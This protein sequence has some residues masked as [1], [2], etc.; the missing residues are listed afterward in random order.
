[1]QMMRTFSLSLSVNIKV[2]HVLLCWLVPKKIEISFQEARIGEFET[3][4]QV[5]ERAI[6]VA[7]VALHCR[8]IGGVHQVDGD[9]FGRISDVVGRVQSADVLMTGSHRVLS[10]IGARGVQ[11]ADGQLHH[12]SAPAA[13]VTSAAVAPVMAP[14]RA[15]IGV[16]RGRESAA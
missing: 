11:P 14:V 6:Y 2:Y 3:H 1:M 12:G 9:I 7:A 16:R 13:V 5:A 4:H 10:N 15:P 8:V